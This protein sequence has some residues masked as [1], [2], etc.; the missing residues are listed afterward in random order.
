[1]SAKGK[2]FFLSKS[3]IG[4]LVILLGIILDKFGVSIGDT[5]LLTEQ[6][7]EAISAGMQSVGA[8]LAI[9]GRLRAD[10]PITSVAGIS[11]AGGGK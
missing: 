10:T 4:V 8:I 1:M 11:V 2:D 7:S 9:Y 6:L 3:N 5:E